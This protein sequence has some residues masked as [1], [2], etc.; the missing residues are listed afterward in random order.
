MSENE[1]FLF[2]LSGLRE[3]NQSLVD[4]FFVSVH[5]TGLFA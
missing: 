5:T 1:A 3:C 2:N 4:K